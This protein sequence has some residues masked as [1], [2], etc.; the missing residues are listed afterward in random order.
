MITKMFGR[1]PFYGWWVVI[2]CA[3]IQ[4]YL[5]G[6]FIYGFTAVFNP[7]TEEF[8]WS[9]AMTSLAFSFRGF[10]TGLLAPAA[11]FLVDRFSTRKLFFAGVLITSLGFLLF[12]RVSSLVS[13]YTAIIVLTLG[14]SFISPVLTITIVTRWFTKHTTL[15]IGFVTTGLAASGLLVPGVVW[16]VDQLGW[17]NAIFIFGIGM[18]LFCIPLS[19]LVKSPPGAQLPQPPESLPVSGV[20]SVNEFKKNEVSK[21]LK[22]KDFW[23]LAAAVLFSGVAGLAI[24]VHLIP[25]QVS[26]GITRQAAGLSAIVFSLSNIGG[27][28][29]FGLLGDAYDRRYILALAGL[30][31]GLGILAFAMS[32]DSTHFAIS[33]ALMGIGYGGIVP[34]RPVLQLDLFGRE[35]FGTVQGLLM[36]LVTVGSIVAPPFAGWMFDST[37]S[38]RPAF[39]VLSIV[40]LLT[41]PVTLAIT[42][43]SRQS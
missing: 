22:L 2:A 11:G 24:I 3:A 31:N 32:T 4:F 17:K 26:V 37:G 36:A 27:R 18:V 25:Y 30:I 6:T 23:L 1:K 5:G 10:E 43:R 12:S 29:I 13:L 41:I 34:L 28:V 21:I 7:L 19:L 39:V 15:A 42:K 16:V 38:Y 9:Y 20:K 35:T 14:Y 8:G 33:L 40:S